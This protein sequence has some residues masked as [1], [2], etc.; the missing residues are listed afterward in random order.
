MKSI[1]LL[2]GSCYNGGSITPRISLAN[3]QKTCP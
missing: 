3:Y 2:N 1:L